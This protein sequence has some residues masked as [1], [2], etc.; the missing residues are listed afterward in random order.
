MQVHPIDYSGLKPFVFELS[1]IKGI[2]YAQPSDEIYACPFDFFS[3][4]MKEG[5]V[6][7]DETGSGINIEVMLCRELSFDKYEITTYAKVSGS[8]IIITSTQEK[9]LFY[10]NGLLKKIIEEIDIYISYKAILDS[11]LLRLRSDLLGTFN[12]SG[13]ARYKTAYGIKK[14]YKP[15]GIVYVKERTRDVEEGNQTLNSERQGITWHHSWSVRSH[16]RRLTSGSLGLNRQGERVVEG[17]TWIPAYT[18][19]MGDF[20]E[21]VRLVK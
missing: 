10:V 19:G 3:I 9:T 12:A 13:K 17:A 6:T 2:S 1:N 11:F 16:Y 15:V 4:E 5:C 7:V 21:K 20:V 8:V 18:K 14:V